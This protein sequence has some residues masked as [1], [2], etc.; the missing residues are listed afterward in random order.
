MEEEPSFIETLAMNQGA[1]FV[2][3]ENVW[4]LY[5]KTLLKHLPPKETIV[6][7]ISESQKNLDVVQKLYDQIVERP[8]KRNLTMI[9]FGGGI[10]QD[11]TGFV[12]ST[13]YRGLNWI[14]VPT[15]LLA[16][17][18]SCIG[19]KTSLNYRKYKNLIGTFFPPTCIHTYPFF[20]QTQ[21][22]ADF[23]SGF[24]EVI[25]L[26]LMEGHSH[27][28][29][30]REQAP[31]I[32]KR[33]PEALFQ[34]IHQSL[35]IKLKYIEEDEF[36]MGHR[37]LLNYGHDFGHALE[38]T[39]N[40]VIPHGQAVIFGMLAANIISKQRGVLDGDIEIEIA[41]SLLLPNLITHPTREAISAELIINAMKKDKKRIGDKLALIMMG[42]NFTFTRVNDLEPS[43]VIDALS[44]LEKR[45]F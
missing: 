26:H 15:T 31:S 24:G 44:I 35:Q 4:N 2:I 12:A 29:K 9:S 16:Q 1:V 13:I 34:S 8:A 36:D 10:L 41:N 6:L 33:C 37:N 30:L 3:D 42:N 7:P 14:Y 45:L 40:F 38:N 19:S 25:K 17:A 21:L 28:L 43:E 32:L 27:Y 5:A 39:S 20:L 22:D 23:L 11:I 18:D